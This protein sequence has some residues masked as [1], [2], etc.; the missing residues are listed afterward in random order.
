MVAQL[1]SESRM[2]CQHLGH[3]LRCLYIVAASHAV[4][5]RGSTKSCRGLGSDAWP[6]LPRR[7]A[8][9]CFSPCPWVIGATRAP[10]SWDASTAPQAR[11]G[12]PGKRSRGA[13]GAS[14]RALPLASLSYLVFV[15][16]SF[17]RT[18]RAA[19]LLVVSS[20]QRARGVA[21]GRSVERCS[22]GRPL[23]DTGTLLPHGRGL[24]RIDSNL[25][26]LPVIT[27]CG[28]P[29]LPVR[30]RP[31][32]RSARAAVTAAEHS[33]EGNEVTTAREARIFRSDEFGPARLREQ[34]RFKDSAGSSVA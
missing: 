20:L 15:V 10:I 9:Y 3:L 34:E 4:A 2:L 32:P 14:G 25:L 1:A 18:V 5:L 19:R 7:G 6:A 22:T 28:S 21:S 23:K 12:G 33:T 30:S 31:S 24:D 26:A 13:I 17:L 27:I 16:C 8:F 11:S 29:R